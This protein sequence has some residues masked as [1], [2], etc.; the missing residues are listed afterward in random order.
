MPPYTS[1]PTTTSLPGRASSAIAAVVAEPERE[2]DAVLAA[3][4]RR[5]RALQALAGRVL[6]ARVLV[7]AARAPDA[8]LAV[9]GGL[10][11]GRRDG[12]GQLVGLLAGVDGERREAGVGRQPMVVGHGPIIARDRRG[13]R[14]PEL[15]WP[16]P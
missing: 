7:A 1:S 2:G 5:D 3:F 9:R 16:W 15:M 4:E 11:D 6:G 10:V 8:V 13:S 12:A 14:R